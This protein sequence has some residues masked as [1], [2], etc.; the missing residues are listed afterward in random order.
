MIFINKYNS[1]KTI[2]EY[3]VS[4]KEAVFFIKFLIYRKES[5]NSLNNSSTCSFLI[6]S[7]VV[8]LLLN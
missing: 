4:S 3:D 5:K 6:D 2:A 1:I 8:F 7:S